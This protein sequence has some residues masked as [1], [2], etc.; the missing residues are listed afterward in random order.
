[1]K[2][3]FRVL[4]Q[5]LGTIRRERHF[6][7]VN[8]EIDADKK[9]IQTQLYCYI[10]RSHFIVHRTMKD[11]EDDTEREKLKEDRRANFVSSGRTK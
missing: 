3:E 4:A 10:Y 11:I 7:E 8:C 2:F 5:S 1:M 6:L 9:E